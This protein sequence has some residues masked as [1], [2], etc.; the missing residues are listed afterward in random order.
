MSQINLDALIPREDFEV[1]EES[2]Q[3]STSQTIQIR[4]LENDSFFYNSVRK[5]DFQRETSDWDENKISEFVKSFLSGDLIPS[6]ILWNSGKYVFVID[7]A[8]R[9]S[10][11]ISWV[12]DDY[13]DGV[14]SKAFYEHEIPE[15]QILVAQKTRRKI[16]KSFGSYKEHIHAIRNPDKS[17][18]EVLQRAQR[19]AS[20]AVQLQW[21]NGNAEKAEESFFKIN[22]HAAP[23]NNTELRLLKSRKK[24]NAIAA[25]AIIRSG[26]GHK[27]WSKFD[28]NNQNDIEQIA[29]TINELLFTPKL[30]TPIK[31]LDIP[32]AGKSYSPQT[33]SLILDLINITNNV[34][35][36]EKLEQD[37]SGNETIQY[38]KKCKKILN[39]TTGTHPSSLG[40]HP[41]AYFYSSAGRYQIT[42]FLAFLELI[43]DYEKKNFF[44][45][46]TSVRKDFENFIVTHKVFVK[47]INYKYGSGTKS[48]KR[49]KDIYNYIVEKLFQKHSIDE[50]VKSLI[51]DPRFN[52][53]KPDE[54]EIEKTLR[55]DFSTDVK[56][57][58]FIRDA[59]K[60]PLR[61]KICNGLIHTNSI[62]IDHIE[63][64]EDGGLGNPENAQLTHP[65]CNS[66]IKN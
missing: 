21:V 50:A 16:E 33:L 59:L 3:S 34:L 4:D 6:V 27:Y 11:L 38:L 15:E 44:P 63:R 48:Y 18:P 62:S 10:A 57:T 53:L 42:A 45:E 43:K 56:S 14:I 28:E 41:V 2:T 25:R 22:Q 30:K 31:T 35:N 58:S 13:G 1:N 32:L 60:S 49:L 8:H 20:L 12:N 40:L 64:K 19:L 51:A 9:L 52:F 61:C 29:K 55:K 37:E 46:F 24:P 17:D 36:D 47:Q 66:T 23:I 7:G 54:S 5:P 65:F 26:S 39:R